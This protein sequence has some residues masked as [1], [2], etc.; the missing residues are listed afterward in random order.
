MHVAIHP[1][2]TLKTPTP[3]P[4]QKIQIVFSIDSDLTYSKTV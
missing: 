3:S 2:P 4:P 1:H